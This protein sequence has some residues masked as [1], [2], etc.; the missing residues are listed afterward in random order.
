MIAPGGRFRVKSTFDLKS[1]EMLMMIGDV[2]SGLARA[3]DRASA[4]E[5]SFTIAAVEMLCHS[6]R[7]CDVALGFRY[8]DPAQLSQLERLAAAVELDLIPPPGP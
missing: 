4:A 6:D 3:G 1:R 8:T 5:L 7:R 2:V